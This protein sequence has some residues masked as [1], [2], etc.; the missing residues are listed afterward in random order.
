MLSVDAARSDEETQKTLESLS[1]TV[2]GLSAKL[3]LSS[4]RVKQL[5]E[6][7]HEQEERRKRHSGLN[8]NWIQQGL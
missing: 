7:L 6:S 8:L 1:N 2:L 5:S 4:L 3:V